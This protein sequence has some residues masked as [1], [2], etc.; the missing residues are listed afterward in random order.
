MIYNSYIYNYSKMGNDN[1]TIGQG[2]FGKAKL[3][4][5][6]NKKAVVKY[7]NTTNDP[8]ATL[9]TCTINR[10][11]A[12]YEGEIMKLFKDTTNIA[13][14]YDIQG[15][16]IYMKY[17]PLGSLRDLLDK[18]GIIENRY[19]LAIGIIDGLIQIHRLNYVHCD[20]KASNIL[21]EEIDCKGKKYIRP[22]ISDFGGARL[23]G[24]KLDAYTPGFC[25]PEVLDD[26]EPINFSTDLYALGKL[27][28][29]L[30]T[31]KKNIKD[32]TYYNFDEKFDIIDF[33]DDFFPLKVVP[34][35]YFSNFSEYRPAKKVYNAVKNCLSPD[36]Y[37]RT[38]LE[39]FKYDVFSETVIPEGYRDK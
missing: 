39:S 38:S 2:G 26:D 8:R 4:T 36:K 29:E 30:F 10:K 35:D 7:I 21:C 20:L 9:A 31:Y 12:K 11:D 24:S 27:F 5:Y 16:A 22:V 19:L 13:T 34:K 18:K 32:I 17:Y 37:N 6:N 3:T 1:S 28:I 14:I 33:T 15:H 25:P 23:K